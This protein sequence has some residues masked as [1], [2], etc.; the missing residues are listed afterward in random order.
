MI[1]ETYSESHVES[2]KSDYTFSVHKYPKV[3]LITVEVVV[4]TGDKLGRWHKGKPSTEYFLVPRKFYDEH[5]PCTSHQWV[6]DLPRDQELTI[7]T[8]AYMDYYISGVP[9]EW[10][11]VNEGDR[12]VAE[13]KWK[14]ILDSGDF[15]RVILDQFYYDSMIRDCDGNPILR[16]FHVDYISGQ[17]NERN[18]D[19]NKLAAHLRKQ[20]GVSDLEIIEIPYYNADFSGQKAIEFTF[21]PSPQLFK[22]MFINNASFF[23]RHSTIME[24]LKVEKFRIERDD[25]DQEESEWD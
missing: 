1:E 22:K 17:L 19:L 6:F 3:V 15:S 2:R 10:S 9:H 13:A 25:E 21:L 23:S 11:S 5:I 8:K 16:A 18:Y 24:Y 12:Y 20:K 14:K 7:A 4:S